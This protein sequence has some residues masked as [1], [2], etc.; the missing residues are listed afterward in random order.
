MKKII[1]FIAIGAL[2]SILVFL[3]LRKYFSI[4]SGE[5]GNMV[6]LNK[7]M[8]IESVAFKN[9]ELL[10]IKY[11]CDGENINPPL[12]FKNIP[13]GTMSLA[14]VLE[15][16]HSPLHFDG[17]WTHWL[18][19][20]IPADTSDIN[21]GN[22]ILGVVGETSEGLVKYYGPCASNAET[23]YWFRL[24]ALDS[25]FT[26]NAEDFTLNGENYPISREDLDEAMR[27]H[28]LTEAKLI[29]KLN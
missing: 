7:S 16:P 19:W 26:L 13:E 14:L 27:G 18:V 15:N 8:E 28:V 22:T 12:K 17:K 21:E 29:G 6:S 4:E 5:V 25:G 20:N 24:F 3:G 1:T 11:T 9:G 10:P 23:E 2:V